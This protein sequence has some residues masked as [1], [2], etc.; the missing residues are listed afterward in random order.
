M[1]YAFLSMG[2]F[3]SPKKMSYW[4]LS[5]AMHT[6]LHLPGSTRG[7]FTAANSLTLFVWI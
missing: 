4:S 2:V 6:K 3:A 7:E 5:D 1:L